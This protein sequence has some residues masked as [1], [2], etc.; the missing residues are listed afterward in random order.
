MAKKPKSGVYAGD[1]RGRV[2]KSRGQRDGRWYWRAERFEGG[3]D[4]AIGSG[5]YTYGQAKAWIVDLAAGLD[6][7][8]K[9]SGDVAT[10][11][12]LLAAYGSDVESRP[13]LEPGT[14]R[15]I[16]TKVYAF[17]G[18]PAKR[19]EKLRRKPLL[20]TATIGDVLVER[21]GRAMMERH[22]NLR[23]GAG[24]APRT[25]REELRTLRTAWAWARDCGLTDVAPP[26]V[27]D[28]RDQAVRNRR[29]PPPADVAAI[30]PRLR[31]AWQRVA[32]RLL[33]ATGCRVGEIATMR[34]RDVR[35]GELTV[36]VDGK[37]GAR[38]VPVSPQTMAILRPLLVDRHPE[39]PLWPVEPSTVRKHLGESIRKACLAAGVPVFTPHG[40]RRAAV[41]AMARAGVDAATAASITGHSV[42]VMLRF[43]RQVTEDDRRAA[44]RTARLGVLP[45]DLQVVDPGATPPTDSAQHPEKRGSSDV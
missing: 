44:V 45:G 39:A 12:D 35:P 40:L 42:V 6:D 21:V 19:L 24:V 3:R 15:A 32:V 11:R 27:P 18:W 31:V 20:A 23:I 9:P 26:E 25:V 36:D 5:W 22:R 16:R 8:P 43:Y 10:V 34:V 7:K 28:V 17:T 1:V 38:S 33:Y 41:D 13:D 14:K 29:T 30:L 4:V 2:V 37:T